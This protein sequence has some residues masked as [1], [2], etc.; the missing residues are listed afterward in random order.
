M[1][2][3]KIA[4]FEWDKGNLDKSY[5][6][7]GITPNQ[8]EEVFLD[9]N[10]LVIDDIKHSSQEQRHVIIGTTISGKT[11][12]IVYTIRK[13]NIRIISART[14]NQKERSVYDQKI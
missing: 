14:A 5:Q 1:A 3:M 7:H 2:L 11:L 9:E 10:A 8:A 4:G 12:F 6:K 13:N